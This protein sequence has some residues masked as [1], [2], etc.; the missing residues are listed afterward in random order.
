[1]ASFCCDWQ[2][3]EVYIPVFKAVLS[4]QKKLWEQAGIETPP[5]SN[6]R[7]R[8]ASLQHRVVRRCPI[9]GL[10]TSETSR[11]LAHAKAEHAGCTPALRHED[12]LCKARTWQ[13]VCKPLPLRGSPCGPCWPPSSFE[14]LHARVCVLQGLWCFL[15][16]A[17]LMRW[18]VFAQGYLA[19]HDPVLPQTT[20]AIVMTAACGKW[21]SVPLHELE[22]APMISPYVAETLTVWGRAV[23][24][25][26]LFF[27]AL[28]LKYEDK[29]IEAPGIH[30]PWRVL[31]AA[32]ACFDLATILG[33]PVP[34]WGSHFECPQEQRKAVEEFW[35]PLEDA[36]ATVA[37][38]AIRRWD[39]LVTFKTV[40]TMRKQYGE[41]MRHLWKL[42]R[43][44]P[45]LSLC[46]KPQVF[47]FK[48]ATRRCPG[49]LVAWGGGQSENQLDH[50]GAGGRRGWSGWSGELS[51]SGFMRFF[52]EGPGRRRL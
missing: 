39:R 48:A 36:F 10:L 41:F 23:S 45:Y 18:V 27:H 26:R 49:P 17:D 2:R 3:A 19:P 33:S 37:A 32:A 52:L 16:P 24:E 44:S 8:P 7:P 1:M 6:R 30:I 29:V 4:L 20:R 40:E 12:T 25:T 21:R 14:V 15:A 50:F 51:R 28:A 38:Y 34:G 43:A 46:C 31:T 13:Q 35:S 42:S 22:V 9:C 11:H 47:N 5:P